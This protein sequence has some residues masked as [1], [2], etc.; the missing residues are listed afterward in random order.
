MAAGPIGR[1]PERTT[2]DA[3]EVACRTSSGSR[4]VPW[5][6]RTGGKRTAE[7]LAR[8]IKQAGPRGPRSP[9]PMD[10]AREA[11]IGQAWPLASIKD[12]GQGKDKEVEDQG[13]KERL[14]RVE[15]EKEEV[16]RKETKEERLSRTRHEG[17]LDWVGNFA[18]DHRWL[19]DDLD[20]AITMV[21]ITRWGTDVSYDVWEDA[22]REA[23]AD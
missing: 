1:S 17:R 18:K 2:S 22:L 12:E 6:S 14:H 5:G 11:T 23:N 21:E 3:A 19:M 20:D 10:W 8:P 7:A 15:N 9:G 16:G 13:K 4:G